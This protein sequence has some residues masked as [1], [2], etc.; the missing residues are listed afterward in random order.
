[1]DADSIVR[2]MIPF[3]SGEREHFRLARVN[4]MF[5]YLFELMY[6]AGSYSVEYLPV[7]SSETQT[8]VLSPVSFSG[9]RKYFSKKKKSNNDP[10]S[11]II[12]KKTGTAIM[13]FQSFE[14]PDR[15]RHFADSMFADIKKNKINNLIIDVRNNGGGI[16]TVGDILLKYITDKPFIQMD[17][18]L[19]KI[20]PKTIELMGVNGDIAPGYYFF[21]PDS[22]DYVKPLKPEE[23]HFD[24]NV[25]LL[26]S[27]KTF[28]SAASF[29]WAFK[30]CGMGTVV[31]EETG[32][33]NVCYGDILIY[34]LP[35]SGLNCSISFKRFWQF[36][37]DETDIH[38]VIPDVKVP[39]AMALD[40]AIGLI[41]GK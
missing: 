8:A 37:A 38:G 21:E 35:V 2:S 22:K 1:M 29:S 23:G 14:D 39:A 31:G 30:E 11:Y 19:V 13:D 27:N 32:G 7:N 26:T 36:K 41:K 5:N 3:V 25:F 15:M 40:K 28:S 16:S 12:D 4:T 17:R 20:T 33:M 34:R 10:Y 24:G 6:P 18:G 9:F